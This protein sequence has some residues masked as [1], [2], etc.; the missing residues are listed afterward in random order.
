M[1]KTPEDILLREV[2]DGLRVQLAARPTGRPGDDPRARFTQAALDRLAGE[3][4]APS[5]RPQEVGREIAEAGGGLAGAMDD[6]RAAAHALWDR[7]RVT[8]RAG[9]ADA[10]RVLLERGGDLWSEFERWSSAVQESYQQVLGDRERLTAH[11]REAFV[12]ALLTGAGGNPSELRRSADALELPRNGV[13][14]VVVIERTRRTAGPTD[15]E[16]RLRTRGIRSAWRLTLL[17]QVGVVR[18]GAPGAVAAGGPAAGGTLLKDLLAVTAPGRVGMS[19]FYEQLG[20]TP[21]AS[22]LAHLALASLPSG[23]EEVCQYGDRPLET[24]LAAAPESSRD[25][26]LT[27]LS[28]LLALSDDA[29]ELLLHTVAVWCDSGGSVTSAAERLHCHRNTVRYRLKRVEELTGRSLSAP[30]GIAEVLVAVR[31]RQLHEL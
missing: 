19:T 5:C 8:A 17:E 6:I 27:V 26:G 12:D 9:D 23:A 1:H 11:E 10:Y 21:V 14:C 7:A 4:C 28:G 15:I 22:R 3:A 16:R 24:L 29:R 18:L 20:F 13:F 30:Q 31:A 25:L 2:A